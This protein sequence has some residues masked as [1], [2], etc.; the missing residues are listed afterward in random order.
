MCARFGYWLLPVGDDPVACDRV[1]Y[2][3]LFFR[4]TY[5]VSADFTSLRYIGNYLCM[6][7]GIRIAGRLIRHVG[8]RRRWALA[9]T[10]LGINI[11]LAW[12]VP[13]CRGI[14]DFDVPCFARVTHAVPTSP[15]TFLKSICFNVLKKMGSGEV[16]SSWGLSI[17]P[18]HARQRLL[19]IRS[20]GAFTHRIRNT[21]CP[22]LA[23]AVCAPTP[24][25]FF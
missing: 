22:Q 4:Q 25:T 8:S 15:L 7:I 5:Q 23:C 13:S 3:A 21:R 1:V 9:M 12:L 18:W 19:S 20:N 24:A 2:Q 14:L 6:A 11:V 17:S 10:F 16:S